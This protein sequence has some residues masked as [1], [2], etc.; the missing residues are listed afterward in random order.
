MSDKTCIGELVG[1]SDG[2]LA[3]ELVSKKKLA[4]GSRDFTVKIWNTKRGACLRTLVGHTNFVS[5]LRLVAKDKLASGS[6]DTTIK[7]WNVDNG[8]CLRT[9]VGHADYVSTL[10]NYRCAQISERITRR[11]D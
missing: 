2:V 9:L 6:L 10:G 4:S 3:L 8:E 5:S 11:L 7:I 1:H